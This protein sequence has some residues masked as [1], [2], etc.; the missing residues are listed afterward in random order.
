M[1]LQLANG[2]RFVWSIVLFAGCGRDMDQRLTQ[3]HQRQSVI[4]ARIASDEKRAANLR[5]EVKQLEEKV[6]SER[7]CLERQACWAQVARAN[8][9][10]AAELAECN[11]KSA[12]FGAAI[13]CGAGGADAFVREA[14]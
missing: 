5:A 9:A 1:K 13:D 12:N 7:R 8:A 10:I 4:D 2:L 6:D 3:I 14:A 11:R